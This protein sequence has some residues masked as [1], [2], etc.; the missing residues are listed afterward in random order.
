MFEAFIGNSFGRL[1]LF[2]YTWA[3]M[4]HG[5]GGVRHLIWDM[6]HGFEPAERD[7]L[8]LATLVGS[9]VL[10]IAAVGASAIWRWEARDERARSARYRTAAAPRARPRRG[11]HRHRT[12]LAQR[13]T[14][15]ALLFLTIAFVVIVIALLGRNHAAVVQILG[16]PLVAMLMLLFIGTVD[17]SHVDRHAGD[18]HRLRA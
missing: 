5:L 17:L 14:S 12:F 6:G 8:T 4:H 16:S 13:V 1:I 3:L 2:G 10:T 7:M 18:H 11:A 15:V 9:I